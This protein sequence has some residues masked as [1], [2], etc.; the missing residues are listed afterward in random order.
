MKHIIIISIFIIPL[1][2]Q[3]QIHRQYTDQD[4]HNE[5]VVVKHKDADDQAIL[6]EIG[7]QSLGLG[8]VVRISTE[9]PQPQ[10]QR[11]ATTELTS[12]SSQQRIYTNVQNGLASNDKVENTAS[13]STN[14]MTEAA[15]TNTTETVVAETAIVI[16]S[17]T[18]DEFTEKG[19]S[20]DYLQRLQ[21]AKSKTH[22]AKKSAKVV[23]KADASAAFTGWQPSAAYLEKRQKQLAAQQQSVEARTVVLAQ[24]PSNNRAKQVSARTAIQRTSQTAQTSGNS[25][26]QA[27]KKKTKRFSKIK[28]KKRKRF[29][30]KKW[31]CFKF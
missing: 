6:A 21:Q 16:N 18:T 30:G 8:D 3:A 5:T 10:I 19:V 13:I 11:R 15:I 23:V 28:L 9:M 22:N 31:T 29:R 27:A 7:Q 24:T 17:P 12:A 2:T 20:A 14:Q 25:S 1:I 26:Y 4:N